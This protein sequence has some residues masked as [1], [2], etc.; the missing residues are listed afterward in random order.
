MY[1]ILGRTELLRI[2]WY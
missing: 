1:K 2:K